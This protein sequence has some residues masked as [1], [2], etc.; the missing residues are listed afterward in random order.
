LDQLR[1]LLGIAVL[2]GLCFVFSTNR[3]AIRARTVIWGLGLQL[4]FAFFVLRVPFGQRLFVKA[5][6]L[7]TSFLGYSF[8]G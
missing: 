2:L 7:V 4:V 5:G 1:G 3:R 6:E 8:A